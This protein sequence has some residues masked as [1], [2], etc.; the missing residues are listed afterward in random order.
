MADR[1]GGDRLGHAAARRAAPTEW[2]AFTVWLEADPAHQPPM[3]RRRSPISTAEE[4]PPAP[5][6]DPARLDARARARHRPA[7]AARLL[8]WGAAACRRW[9]PGSSPI[10]HARRRRALCGGDRPGEQRRSS[11]PTAAGST[12]TARTRLAARPRQCR[13]LP[14]LEQGE[15]LFTV[16][17][18][19]ARP[20]EVEAGER[21]HARPRHHLQRRRRA[22]RRRGR[23]VR[24]RGAVRPRRRERSTCRRAWRC[25]G[26]AAAARRWSAREADAIGGWRAGRLSYRS[27]TIDR[28]RRRICR[29]IWA[30]P[31]GRASVARGR[32]SAA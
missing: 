13:A 20:F 31:C 26:A 7:V 19:E 9:S 28:G 12:S 32:A 18:D 3:R 5:R 21:A 10:D 29:A 11:S 17:H 1:R 22:R 30:S 2:E 24:R 6:P 15:A 14:S 16:V 27:A 23:R 25:A 4:L 8:G